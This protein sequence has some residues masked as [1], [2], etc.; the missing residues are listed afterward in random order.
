VC[1]CVGVNQEWFPT[2]SQFPCLPRTSLPTLFTNHKNFFF[3][4]VVFTLP[5][6][7]INHIITPVVLFLVVSEEKG[8]L[9][10][11]F[12]VKVDLGLPEELPEIKPLVTQGL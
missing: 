1:R 8:V 11:T 9:S 12:Q 3:C 4:F 2:S 7:F 5:V 6:I 10:G